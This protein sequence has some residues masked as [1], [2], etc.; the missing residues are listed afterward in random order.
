[1]FK[2]LCKQEKVLKNYSKFHDTEV[3]LTKD[4]LA[5][6]QNSRILISGSTGS[7]K[8]VLAL[9]LILEYL[10][11][12]RL[13][14]YCK[15]PSEAKYSFLQQVL[16]KVKNK[17]KGKQDFFWFYS[18]SEDIVSVDE[19][20]K[21]EINLIVFDDYVLCK[22]AIPRVTDLFIRGRKKNC[23]ILYLTQSY[24][25]TPKIIR[26]QCNYNIFFKVQD[27]RELSHIYQNHTMS[28]DRKTFINIF[29]LAT[30]DPYSFLMLDH[31]T[32]NPEE[33][34]RKNL[35]LGYVRS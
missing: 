29:K 8:T 14:V 3:G 9:N 2:K 25:N 26:L 6:V 19:L 33:S 22:E 30:N 11:W 20:D 10:P 31:Q 4:R 17:D 35:D 23:T 27:D 7:G 32:S 13:Y 15:D 21:K 34:I 16:E 18:A 1:M 5:P 28:L 12:T 24:F